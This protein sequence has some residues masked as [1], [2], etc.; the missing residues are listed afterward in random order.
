MI[1]IENLFDF[2]IESAEL[3]M[4]QCPIIFHAKGL[5]SL[6]NQNL[7]SVQIILA[8]I[9]YLEQNTKQDTKL[10]KAIYVYLYFD[11]CWE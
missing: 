9:I 6:D 1:K 3:Q 2:Q 11:S 7:L 8:I 5:F 10:F 4:S